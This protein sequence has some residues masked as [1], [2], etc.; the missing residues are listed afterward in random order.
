MKAIIISHE[1][2]GSYVMEKSGSFRFVKGYDSRPIGTEI[3]LNPRPVVHFPRLAATVAACLVMTAVLGVFARLWTAESYF[4]YVEANSSVQLVFNRFNRLIDARPL[5]ES[6]EEVLRDLSLRGSPE[7][8]VVS[9]ISTTTSN[10]TYCTGRYSPVVLISFGLLDYYTQWE[11]KRSIAS[12]L[13]TNGTQDID[14]VKVYSYAYRYIAGQLGVSPGRLRLAKGL[15]A[16][17]ETAY[18]GELL[19]KPVRELV[20]A[21]R[22]SQSPYLCNAGT[23][24]NP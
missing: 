24:S 10:S 9:L 13:E 5:N 23:R 3:E 1:N 16:Y 21:S 15:Y 14:L 17:D 4:I 2:G 11:M 6:G 7:D 19:D 8:V 22:Q 12:A 20:A 18:L